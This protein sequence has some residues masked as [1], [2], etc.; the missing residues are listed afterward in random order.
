MNKLKFVIPECFYRGSRHYVRMTKY[1]DSRLKTA[2]MTFFRLLGRPANLLSMTLWVLLL[3]TGT[4][5]AFVSSPFFAE[6]NAKYQTGDFKAAADL[7]QKIVKSG[8]ATSAVYYNL[9][10]TMLRLGQKGEALVDYERA[11]KGA[12]RDKD[13]KWNLRVLQSALSDRIEDSSSNLFRLL[14]E[15]VTTI[16]TLDEIAFSFT[17]GMVVLFVMTLFAYLFPA[18]RTIV[19]FLRSFVFLFLLA[20]MGVFGLQWWE[21]KDPRVVILDKEVVAYYG[22]SEKETKAFLLHEGAEGK[23]L[24]ESQDWYYIA[25][26]NKNTG[27][28]RKNSCEVI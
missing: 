4:V 20:S 21:T 18:L 22:P 3:G 6:A 14:I 5:F 13:L 10:N 17:M 8:S 2:G 27:W 9:G 7:Y 12:P 19:R 24:D 16:W 28:L 15:K 11:R 26:K 25:L 23:V 1:L